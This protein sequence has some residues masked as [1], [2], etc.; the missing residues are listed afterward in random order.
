MTGKR[1]RTMAL[2]RLVRN[3]FRVC[4]KTSKTTRSK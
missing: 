2:Q 3:S 1:F 4:S